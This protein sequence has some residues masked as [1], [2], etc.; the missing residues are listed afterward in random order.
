[1]AYSLA[2]KLTAPQYFATYLNLG[3]IKPG[4]ELARSRRTM[5]FMHLP[6]L[7]NELLEKFSGSLTMFRECC[8]ICLLWQAFFSL[9]K[10]LIDFV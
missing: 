3:V 6:E 7:W 9:T 1:M 5:E 4:A 2:E 8:R 10:L